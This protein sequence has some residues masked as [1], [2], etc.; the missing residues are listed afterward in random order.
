MGTPYSPYGQQGGYPPQDNQPQGYPPPQG[1]GQPAGGQQSNGQPAYGQPAG[2]QPGYGQPAGGQQSYGQ[3]GG[4]QQAYGQP[5]YG[6]QPGYGAQDNA[7]QG[8]GAP[9]GYNY[10]QQGQGGGQYAP[11]QQ[12]YLQGGPVSFGDAISMHWQNITNFSGRASRSAYWWYA[13]A[14]WLA[15][16]V[17]GIIAAIIGSA[18]FS[19]LVY[20]VMVVVGLTSLSLLVRRLHDSD[21]SGWMILLGLIPFVGGIVL[22]VMVCL[23]GTPG[24]NRFG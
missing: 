24:P 9:L 13:L 16:I 21:K 22:L 6:Q 20:V 10:W 5:G 19:V 14:L 15:F 17:L 11:G 2:G 18:A 23:P 4:Q 8:Y 3:G 7:Q 1:Y 12:G